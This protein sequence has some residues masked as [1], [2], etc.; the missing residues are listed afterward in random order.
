MALPS[1]ALD[2]VRHGRGEPKGSPC[3]CS[4]LTCPPS[5]WKGARPPTARQPLP[6]PW[7][8]SPL[9][10]S[11]SHRQCARSRAG[12]SGSPNAGA[13]VW[14]CSGTGGPGGACPGSGSASLWGVEPSEPWP[15]DHCLRAVREAIPPWAQ[16]GGRWTQRAER[17]SLR[18][19]NL[20]SSENSPISLNQF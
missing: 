13:A 3:L 18:I 16:T 19:R 15:A 17:H 20:G 2:S 7:L 11:A 9:R 4:D 1:C 8:H 14:Q 6:A 5:R 10:Q 12:H